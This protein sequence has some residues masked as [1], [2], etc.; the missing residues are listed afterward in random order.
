MDGDNERLRILEE[1]TAMMKASGYDETICGEILESGLL[2]YERP[3]QRAEK[4]GRSL[5]GLCVAPRG[6]SPRK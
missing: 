1:F 5:H 6:T 4:E 3:R 2:G